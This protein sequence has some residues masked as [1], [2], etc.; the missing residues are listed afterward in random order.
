MRQHEVKTI[1][2]PEKIGL[3]DLLRHCRRDPLLARPRWRGCRIVEQVCVCVH[4]LS[5]D[6]RYTEHSRVLSDFVRI[7]PS[8]RYRTP[9]TLI[10]YFGS[11]GSRSILRRNATICCRRHDPSGTFPVPMPHPSP[12][13]TRPRSTPCCVERYGRKAPEVL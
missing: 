10:R 9:R 8:N 1:Y 13:S 11:A 5:L 12:V 3:A 2:G 6:L 4:D 7:Q